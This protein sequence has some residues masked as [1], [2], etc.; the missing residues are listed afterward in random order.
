MEGTINGSVYVDILIPQGGAVFHQDVIPPHFH[1]DTQFLSVHFLH[2]WVGQGD[3]IYSH[4]A[5]QT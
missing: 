2:R 4:L 1:T 3:Q 5:S